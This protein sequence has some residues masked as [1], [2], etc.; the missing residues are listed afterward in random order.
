MAT[1]EMIQLWEHLDQEMR[2]LIADAPLSEDCAC[3]TNEYLNHN[4]FGLA[5]DTLSACLRE[6][7]DPI[8]DRLR[9]IEQLMYPP[10]LGWS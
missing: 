1:E 2:S 3:E 10:D 4:E 8:L 6:A 5:W 7:D 9:A